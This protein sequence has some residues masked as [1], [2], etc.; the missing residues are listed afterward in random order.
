MEFTREYDKWKNDTVDE[1]VASLALRDMDASGKKDLGRL[2]GTLAH[3]IDRLWY[4]SC[5]EV[6]REGDVYNPG[7]RKRVPKIYTI[8][9]YTPIELHSIP[10]GESFR[11]KA[12]EK[13]K[14]NEKYEVIVKNGSQI[15]VRNVEGYIS[16][17]EG[18]TMILREGNLARGPDG[19]K[20]SK[21][22][23]ATFPVGHYVNFRTVRLNNEARGYFF[24][25]IGDEQSTPHFM[26]YSGLTGACINAMLVNNFV[27]QS[28]HGI[29]FADRFKI[30]SKE[31]NWSNGEVVTRGT[32]SNY[33]RDGFLRP[34]FP[35]RDGIDYLHSKVIEWMETG[36]DLDDILSRDWKSKFAAA[37]VPKG[38]ELN[39]TFIRALYKQTRSIVF[40]KFI[41][42]V[43]N[44]DQIN[45]AGFVD[46]LCASK[47]SRD[48]NETSYATFWDQLVYSIDGVEETKLDYLRDYH[49][50]I[51]KRVDQTIAQVVEFAT[52]GYL[53][54]ER[55]TAE[56]V[57]II[58]LECNIIA[59]EDSS[60][61]LTVLLPQ[62][63][64]TNPNLSIR[65]LM[66]L[67]WKP[68]ISRTH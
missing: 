44:D 30:Y 10:V 32:G 38:M 8:N 65:L 47:A 9:S 58:T 60:I 67:R 49:I 37:L 55:I 59:D 25:F 66:I 5:L 35:Y 11:L 28:L 43:K 15:L 40:D 68:R 23:L 64:I 54:D 17:M 39:T 33:G 31:T 52:K 18:K 24:A 21:V 53:Y 61:L 36:Q 51:A 45:E 46:Q 57:R 1:L 50:E 41:E 42:V 22:A 26:R 12:N 7:A 62:L 48:D 20:E 14:K 6:I 4:E 63:S 2:R 27:G 29:S 3:H 19:N 56:L 16:Q 13:E 34:G